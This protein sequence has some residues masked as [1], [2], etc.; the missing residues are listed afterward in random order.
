LNQTPE[1]I[2]ITSDKVRNQEAVD[3]ARPFCIE[4]QSNLTTFRGGPN[5]ACKKIV[6]LEI[7]RKS[8]DDVSVMIVQLRKSQDDVSVMIVQLNNFCMKSYNTG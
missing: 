3:I 2:E 4:K 6:E 8:Q 7:T 5:A 1:N